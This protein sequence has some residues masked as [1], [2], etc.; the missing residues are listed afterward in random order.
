VL[1]AKPNS[2]LDKVVTQLSSSSSTSSST[3]QAARTA[4]AKYANVFTSAGNPSARVVSPSVPVKSQIPGH[5]ALRGT[6][7]SGTR[8]GAMTPTGPPGLQR[9]L[10]ARGD[11]INKSLE[12][13]VWVADGVLNIE[14]AERMLKWHAE[15]VGRVVELSPQSDV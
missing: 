2:L 5:L 15:A 6:D 13:K 10:S 3:A 4:I 9:S 8:S 7:T 11:Q 14:M 12:D 1:K